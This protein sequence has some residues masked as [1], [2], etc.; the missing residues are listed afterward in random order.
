MAV[1]LIM[2]GDIPAFLVRPC[3][4][5]KNFW[6]GGTPWDVQYTLLKNTALLL[7]IATPELLAA[8]NFRTQWT[9]KT[10]NKQHYMCVPR[11]QCYKDPNFQLKLCPIIKFFRNDKS[12]FVLLQPHWHIQCI[13]Y[14][15]MRFAMRKYA[16][17]SMNF[18]ATF[19][20][21]FNF[22]A[23]SFVPF[24]FRL[25]QFLLRTV[26][27]PDASILTSYRFIS[28]YINS[29]FASFHLRIHQILLRTVSS[30]DTSNLISYHFF[31][32]MKFYFV[33]VVSG[34]FQIS[35]SFVSVSK[36]FDQKSIVHILMHDSIYEVNFDR[37]SG[38]QLW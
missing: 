31:R 21:A 5:F 2:S 29:Y 7:F 37:I 15:T 3:T 19:Y 12:W 33:R 18:A 20:L 4:T 34:L 36:L 38:L 32:Y 24:H 9:G 35:Y 30:P 23:K 14:T 16:L 10:R 6:Y 22:A 1:C 11:C 28:G 25:H 26:S 13:L 8:S 27:S 17:W